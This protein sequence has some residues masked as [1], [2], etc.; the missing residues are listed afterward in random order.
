ML[1]F[2]RR[3]LPDG[4][5]LTYAVSTFRTAS[6]LDLSQSGV[7]PDAVIEADWDKVKL[8]DDPVIEAAEAWILEQAGE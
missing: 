8:P 6:G 2:D 5:R 1:G 3:L 7:L 4:S